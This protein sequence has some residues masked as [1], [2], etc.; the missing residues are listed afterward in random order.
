MNIIY[1]EKAND[2]DKRIEE[3]IIENNSIYDDR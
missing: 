2:N 3:M 1:K